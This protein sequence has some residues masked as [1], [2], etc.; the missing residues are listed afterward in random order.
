MREKPQCGR[1]TSISCLPDVPQPGTKPLTQAYALTRNQTSDL[2]L[3]GTTPNQLSHTG[4]GSAASFF[5]LFCFVL[6]SA[7]YGAFSSITL[8]VISSLLFLMKYS[9]KRIQIINM[10]FSELLQSDHTTT[11]KKQNMTD[12]PEVLPYVLLSNCP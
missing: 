1:E 7:S 5:V 9:C 6:A 11:T 3:C 4:Q 10:Q 12:T 2:S 8:S